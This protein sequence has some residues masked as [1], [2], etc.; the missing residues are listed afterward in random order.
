MQTVLTNMLMVDILFFLVCG[1]LHVFTV[2]WVGE[3]GSVPVT[4]YCSVLT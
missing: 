1:F 3:S 4:F 2:I